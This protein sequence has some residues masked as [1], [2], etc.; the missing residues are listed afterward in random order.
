MSG[1]TSFYFKPAKGEHIQTVISL[2]PEPRCA[3]EGR[4]LDGK[5]RPV[6]AAMVLLYQVLEEGRQKLVSHFFTGTD[7]QFFFGPLPPDTLSMIRIFKDD[8]KL[9]ELE[10]RTE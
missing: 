2:E 10:L 1:H 6:E 7:G 8:V 3:L 4:L 9:R 5:D